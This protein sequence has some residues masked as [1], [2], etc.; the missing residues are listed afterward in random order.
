MVSTFT[1]PR[2]ALQ[3]DDMPLMLRHDVAPVLDGANGGH[4]VEQPQQRIARIALPAGQR[5]LEGDQR[6]VDRVGDLLEM[7][8]RHLGALPSVNG[9]GGNTS[10]ADAPP[11]VACRA[12][13]AA[14]RLP[15][16]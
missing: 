15:S 12:R 6:Q 16:A 8:D 9:P 2:T 10:S 14:S 7:R 5:I 4:F 11:A 1:G 13:R 3:L